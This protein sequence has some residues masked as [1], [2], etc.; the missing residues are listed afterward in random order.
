MEINL[1]SL[2]I[3][4]IPLVLNLVLGAYIILKIH[5]DEQN[6]VFLMFLGSLISWQLLEVLMRLRISEESKYLIDG[7]LSIGWIFL[8]AFLLHFVVLLVNSPLKRIRI[9]FVIN[10]GVTLVFYLLYINYPEP[11]AFNHHSFFSDIPVTRPGSPDT[12]KRAWIILQVFSAL[13]LMG[14]FIKNRSKQ[15]RQLKRVK[16]VRLVFTGVLIPAVV[17]FFTQWLLPLFGVEDIAITATSMTA[18]SIFTFYGMVKYNLFN[19]FEHISFEDVLKEMKSVM[20]LFDSNLN[21]LLKNEFTNS[22]TGDEISPVISLRDLLDDKSGL[23]LESALKSQPKLSQLT[24]LVIKSKNNYEIPVEVSVHKIS[25]VAGK[26]FFLL[27]G[28]D[29]S[30][31]FEY[32]QKLMAFNKYF[33]Y[34]LEASNESFFELNPST[35]EIS[36]NDTEFK[37]FGEDKI[38]LLYSMTG[39]EKFFN[40]ADSN[41]EF[42]KLQNWIFGMDRKPISLFFNIKKCNGESLYLSLN[43]IKV[44]NGKKNNYRV[45]GTLRDTSSEYEYFKKVAEKDLILRE[46]AWIQSHRVRA[47]LANILGLVWMLKAD[48]DIELEERSELLDSLEVAA[49]ELD[50]VLKEIV[51][52]ANEIDA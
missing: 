48:G 52:K 51:N 5:K 12:F 44:M 31:T 13:S 27:F 46:I 33:R 16:Q 24:Q 32:K 30:E 3:V 39:L 42:V 19:Y 22:I 23:T 8:G 17:G 26:E 41:I 43:A 50:N 20:I 6:N 47:Q 37:I 10:Y 21:V 2:L 25:E 45:I 14:Y 29:I 11:V 1:I 9:F 28:N 40:D 4:L 18:I 34:F 49:E 36:W 7:Y 15:K 38:E 35:N